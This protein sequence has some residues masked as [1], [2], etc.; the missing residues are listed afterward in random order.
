MSPKYLERVAQAFC[1]AAKPVRFIPFSLGHINN[2]FF[3]D[4]G[5]GNPQYILQRI[6]TGIF[7][8]PG[9]LMF[10]I[11][12]ISLHIARKVADEGGDSSRRS[13]TVIATNY[14]GDFYVDP[15]GGCWRAFLEI[16]MWF[17][18]ILPMI[19]RYCIKAQLPLA[20]FEATIR[21]SGR[22]SL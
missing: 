8:N 13:R 15:D 19:P 1:F 6:N 14:G 7:Q 22:R 2:T 12:E 4:C 16:E 21:L 5:E 9:Q 20:A 10:N 3:V 11:K 18:M 17:P